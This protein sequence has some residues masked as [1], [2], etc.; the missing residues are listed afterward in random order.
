MAKRILND[1]QIA[2]AYEQC[3]KG[4]TTS[5]V[6]K[7][8]YVSRETMARCFREYRKKTNEQCLQRGAHKRLT[9]KQIK[10]AHEKW[11][12]GYALQK[13]GKALRVSRSLIHKN[14]AMYRTPETEVRNSRK[15]G[16]LSYAE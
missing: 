11:I 3:Q 10:W 2:W 8:L 9:D 6:A 14:I 7:E 5:D 15:K 1:E 4:S 13:I 12:E 16:S